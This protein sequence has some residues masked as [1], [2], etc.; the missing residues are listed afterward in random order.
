MVSL[1]SGQ[2]I[3]QTLNIG[4]IMMCTSQ[5]PLSSGAEEVNGKSWQLITAISDEEGNDLTLQKQLSQSYS[6]THCC[7]THSKRCCGG[8][9]PAILHIYGFL[10]HR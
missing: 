9:F 3:L 1:Q 7:V 2:T 10:Q 4:L 5:Q 8:D 6:C